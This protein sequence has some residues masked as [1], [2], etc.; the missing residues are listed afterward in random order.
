MVRLRERSFA[1]GNSP[2]PVWSAGADR[3]PFLAGDALRGIA[4]V[5]IIFL[6]LAGGSLALTDLYTGNDF[7]SY[8]RIP[9][10]AMY[11]LEFALPMFFVLSGYLISA[12]WIRAY[13]LGRPP[14]ALRRYLRNRVLRI[15]P[16]FWLLSAVML[17]IYGTNGASALHVAS[18]FG[19]GQIY[20]NS[21][22]QLSLLGQAWS[23][24]VEVG[25]YLLVPVVAFLLTAAT[26]R[27]G[28]AAG[29]ELSPR[30]RI[31]LILSL[32]T[33]A[34]VASA[35]FQVTHLGTAWT[36]APIATLYSFAP[37]IALAALEIALVG[38]IARRR[39]RPLAPILGLCSLGLAVVVVV[40]ASSNP[41]L[42]SRAR[43]ELAAAAVCGLAVAALLTRQAVRGDSPRWVDN[44][45]TRWLGACSYPCYIVQGATIATGVAIV[46]RASGGPWP[47]LLALT[48]FV[49]PTTIVV[50]SVVHVAFERPVLVWGRGRGSRTGSKGGGQESPAAAAPP[51][52]SGEAYPDAPVSPAAAE[53]PSA[54]NSA[55]PLGEPRPVQ[56]S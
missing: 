5:A 42:M 10:T 34:S 21:G 28:A 48:A 15:V 22:A 37:G 49:I 54:V 32:L 33:V 55:A 47:E 11:A 31:A 1:S 8:G 43:G 27:A 53:P 30:G 12:P 40:A 4:M 52:E 41:L 3:T 29:R 18:L 38:P 39:P 45:A 24:D 23:I 56:A 7:S 14:P 51:V 26:R 17:A 16:V 9:G 20:V 44:P 36:D 2:V 35:W 25:F 19:F 46:G 6:H 50:G 13:V